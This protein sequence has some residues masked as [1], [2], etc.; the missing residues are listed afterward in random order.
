MSKGKG[1]GRTWW[2]NLFEDHP[3]AATKDPD[4][5]HQSET[6]NTKTP[7][8]YC[9]ACLIADVY[10]I[11]VEDSSGI[12][13]GREGVNRTE[14]EIKIHRELMNYD[15]VCLM[16]TVFFGVWGKARLSP[17]IGGFI[18]YA[19]Q[20][21]VNHLRSCANQPYDVREEAGLKAKS[22]KKQVRYSPYGT[23]QSG[24]ILPPATFPSGSRSSQMLPPRS[25]PPSQLNSPALH[26]QTAMLPSPINSTAPSPQL[27]ALSF[28]LIDPLPL[29][30]GTPTLYNQ[31][32]AISSLHV[33]PASPL[34]FQPSQSPGWGWS[35]ELQMRFEIQ[36][37]RLTAAAGLPLSWVD[38]PEWID[39]IHLFLPAARSP[40]RKVLTTRLIPEVVEEYTRIAKESSSGQNATIQADGWTGANFH[41][42]LA[43]MI[44][45]KNKVGST[46]FY[47]E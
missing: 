12:N 1:P 16:L 30:N 47:L 23:P 7:K 29:L 11:M 17:G 15:S 4:A 43:F 13:Q 44:A 27:S 10:Q 5:F 9:K 38:N 35:E 36:I 24:T 21:C 45:V 37:A 14:H 19:M 8:V 31:S 2:R 26:V 41:H 28:P 39:F 34:I 18:I 46:I 25:L 42:L 32:L 20:T 40:S 33:E 3:G 6:G 22:P